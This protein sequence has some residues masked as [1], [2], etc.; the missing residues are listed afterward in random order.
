MRFYL[1]DFCVFISVAE[2]QSLSKAALQ[3]GMSVS[4]VSKR[5]SR[6]ESHLEATLFDRS[7]R[8]L[9]LSPVGEVAYERS[10]SMTA[11]FEKFIDEIKSTELKVELCSHR[12]DYESHLARWAY[13][14][15]VI[16]KDVKINVSSI[17]S[18]TKNAIGLNQVILS[19]ERSEFPL[20]IHRKLK[21]LKRII[22]SG[23]NFQVESQP[24]SFEDLK[25]KGVI[26]YKPEYIFNLHISG[27]DFELD[28]ME[29]ID[30]LTVSSVDVAI[31]TALEKGSIIFGLPHFLVRKYIDEGVL[32]E[33][34]GDWIIDDLPVYLIWRDREYYK[35]KFSDFLFFIEKKWEL[36]VFP[37]LGTDPVQAQF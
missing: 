23:S 34:L 17:C 11:E 29:H 15:C 3:L 37:S 16:E 32:K 36:E 33:I 1:K 13:D 12:S 4:S 19:H 28:A 8:H 10:I 30:C 21:P 9:K 24:L 22:C 35:E 7:T 6:L 31:E 5:L 26:I 20:A 18:Q 25:E 27:P 14:F 2:T